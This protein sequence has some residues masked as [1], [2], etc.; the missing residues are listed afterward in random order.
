MATYLDSILEWHRDR[1]RGDDRPLEALL[2]QAREMP[3]PRPF[4]G[5]L[6][7]AALATDGVAVI[8]EIKRRS[9]SKGDLLPDLVAAPLAEAYERGGATCL[10]VLTD[11]VH[12]GGS[13]IDLMQARAATALPALRKDFTVW[14]GDVADARLMGADAVLLIV[15]ALDQPQLVDLVALADELRIDAL[16][17]CHDEAEA[18]RALE[19]QATM[20]GINQRDLTTFDVDPG[21]A[22]RLAGLL[23]STVLRVAESGIDGPDSCRRLADAGF[24]AVLVGEHLV[25]SADPVAALRALIEA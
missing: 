10:S 20:V 19:A 6:R 13:S 1:A 22:E 8:A 11:G 4:E 2:D 21:R 3:P 16:V 18:E 14:A 7:A 17:E 25:R 12:F 5:T 23:P 24:S 9:P 15:A